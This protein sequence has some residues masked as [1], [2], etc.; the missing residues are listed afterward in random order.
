VLE[1]GSDKLAGV[2]KAV[3]D[4]RE[5]LASVAGLKPGSTGQATLVRSNGS[6][7]FSRTAS[8]PDA[9]FFATKELAEHLEQ[10][11]ARQGEGEE[12]F[13]FRALNANGEPQ[14]V[15]VAPSQLSRSYP[16]VSWLVAV[17]QSE[18]EFL[19]PMRSVGWYLLALVAATLLFVLSLALWFSMRLAKPAHDVDMDLV[20]HRPVSRMPDTGEEEMPAQSEEP[21]KKIAAGRR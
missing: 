11:R 7:V 16:N 2:L 13:F 17:S 19:S 21:A 1:P 20:E 15:G 5:L 3:I 8:D 12:R 9:R 10:M 14:V 6:I 4:A 18:S